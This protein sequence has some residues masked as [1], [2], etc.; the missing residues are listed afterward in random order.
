MARMPLEGLVSILPEAQSPGLCGLKFSHSTSLPP[1]SE[2]VS[3]HSWEPRAGVA[4][5]EP[6]IPIGQ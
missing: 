4:G 5:G 6:W 1:V 3:A 2:L